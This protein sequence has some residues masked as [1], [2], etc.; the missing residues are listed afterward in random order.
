LF[1]TKSGV[2]T[3]MRI[4]TA[5]RHVREGSK[6]VIRNGWMTFASTSSIAISL[7]IL[8]LFLLLAMNVNNLANQIE[9]QIEIRVYLEVNTPKEQISSLQ[10]QIGLLDEV[11][12]VDFVSKEEGL[13]F[14]R[15]K[16]GADG[17]ELLEG[18]DGENN[19]LYDSFTVEVDDPQQVKAAAEKI[20]ALNEGNDSKPIYKVSYGQGTVETLFKVTNAIRNI[21]LILVAGLAFTAMFLIAN[22]IKLTILARRREIGIMK[23]VGATNSFIRWPFFIE[24]ALLGIIGSVIPVALLLYGYS[25]LIEISKFELGLMLIQLMPLDAIGYQIGALLIAIGVVIGVWGSTISVRKFLKV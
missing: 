22:T 7:F 9:S 15:G 12:K 18:F 11:S 2:T 8:G 1:E 5:V 6:N 13:E 21:G 17:A 14:L 23:L 25:R 24:G 16:L 19:P 3:A 10:N 4:S 20:S